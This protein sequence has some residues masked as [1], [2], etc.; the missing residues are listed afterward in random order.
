LIPNG[1]SPIDVFVTAVSNGGSPVAGNPANSCHLSAT[2]IPVA[3]PSAA[4][5]AMH[6]STAKFSGPLLGKH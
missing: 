2:D 3:T 4:A 5:T 6:P 1:S